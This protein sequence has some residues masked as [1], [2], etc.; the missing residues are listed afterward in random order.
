MALKYRN[1]KITVDGETFDS[2]KE[3]RRYREL[4]LMERGGLISTLRRQ[5]A[6]ELIKSQYE[7]S[8]CVE[9]GVKYMA[10]YC[11]LEDGKTVVEDVKG[12]RTPDYIIKRKLMLERFG[13]KIKEI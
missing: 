10:D 13:I 4:K 1:K 12:V 3:Y 11:Y 7:G 9:R 6:F 8:R 5:V 2:K